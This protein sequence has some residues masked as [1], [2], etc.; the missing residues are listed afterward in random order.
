MTFARAAQVSRHL[1][2]RLRGLRKSHGICRGV[3]AGCASLAAFAGAFARVALG[4]AAFAGMFARAAQVSRHLPG[5]LRG[6]RRSGGVCRDVCGS[7]PESTDEEL[8]RDV[9]LRM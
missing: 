9:D 8:N 1:P 6:L 7:T 5:H 2:G 4:L 3:Y